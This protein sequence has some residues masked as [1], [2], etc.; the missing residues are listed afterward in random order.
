MNKRRGK[1]PIGSSGNGKGVAGSGDDGVGRDDAADYI[2]GIVSPLIHVAL[3]NDL[4]VVAYLLKLATEEAG[5]RSS[6]IDVGRRTH[7]DPSA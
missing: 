4:E 2:R 6:V 3:D 7:R 5:L 1:S